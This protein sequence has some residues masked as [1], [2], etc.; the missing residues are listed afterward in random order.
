MTVSESLRGS[1]L[2][3]LDAEILLCSILKFSREELLLAAGRELSPEAAA[4]CGDFFKRRKSGEPVAYITGERAFFGHSFFVQPGV[5]IPRPE[6][7]HLVEEALQFLALYSKEQVLVAD[8]GC[9]SGCIGLSILQHCP[10]ARLT[11]V[12]K[13]DVACAVTLQNAQRLGLLEKARVVH[14]DVAELASE[15]FDVIVANPPYI[16]FSDTRV[17]AEVRTFEPADALFAGETGLECLLK[18][19]N[20]ASALLRPGG[21]LAMEFGEGQGAEVEKIFSDDLAYENVKI[22]KDLSGRDRYVTALRARES[23]LG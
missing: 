1:G 19:K 2:E 10:D 8:F 11:A 7:E 15:A 16:A 9:G 20:R 22:G 18:W 6:S 3:R 12:D 17:E 14:S 21:F 23:E 13:S 4:Q 5:L